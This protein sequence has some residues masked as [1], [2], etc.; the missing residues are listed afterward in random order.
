MKEKLKKTYEAVGLPRLLIICFF[1]ALLLS[2]KRSH[3]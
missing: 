3:A 1:L 2:S